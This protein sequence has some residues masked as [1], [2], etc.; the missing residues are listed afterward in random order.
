MTRRDHAIQGCKINC[1]KNIQIP[2]RHMNHMAR[3]GEEGDYRKCLMKRPN[4]PNVDPTD[5]IA[6]SNG[7][8]EKRVEMMSNFVADEAVKIFQI[9]R[10]NDKWAIR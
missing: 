9:V 6:C 10:D 7:L 3:D 8:Y 1:V 5:F 2:F 4:F